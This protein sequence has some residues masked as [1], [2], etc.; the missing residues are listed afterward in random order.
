ME[1]NWKEEL[2][3]LDLWEAE[4]LDTLA[5]KSSEAKPDDIGFINSKSGAGILARENGLLEGF[6]DYGLGFRFSRDTQSLMVFAPSIHLFTTSV[7][8]HD[9]IV[10]NTYLKDEYGD[11]DEILQELQFKEGGE[12]SDEKL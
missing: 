7:Q 2:L 12:E 9:K 4:D 5:D 6:S 1:M 10:R 3:K 8:K 11:V